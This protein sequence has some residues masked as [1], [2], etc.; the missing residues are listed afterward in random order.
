MLVSYE[1]YL[2]LQAFPIVI[3]Y[4]ISYIAGQI[5]TPIVIGYNISYIAGQI[6]TPIVIGYDI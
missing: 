6:H 4:N 3:G 5:N 2:P 1:T